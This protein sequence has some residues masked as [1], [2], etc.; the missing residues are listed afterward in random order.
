MEKYFVTKFFLVL[1]IKIL[2]VLNNFSHILMSKQYLFKGTLKYLC[3]RQSKN[4]EIS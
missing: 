1:V 3:C 4:T 2:T